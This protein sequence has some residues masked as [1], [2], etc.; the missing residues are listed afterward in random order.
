MGFR[1][2][3]LRLYAWFAVALLVFSAILMISPIAEADTWTE[4]TN[5][6]F[7][8]GMFAGTEIVGVGAIAAVQ[9][10][11]TH[12]DWV[13][14]TPERMPEP[15]DGYG[16]AYDKENQV[17]TL[18]GGYIPG[19]GNSNET[20]E[21]DFE[22]NNWTRIVTSGSPPARSLPGMAYDIM[23]EV[24]VLF[25]GY[26]DTGFLDDTWEYHS[27]N[28]TWIEI[29][30]TPHPSSMTSSPMVFDTTSQRIILVGEEVGSSDFQTWRY[31]AFQH[32][33]SELHPTV[34]PPSR[35]GHALA[36]DK[37]GGRVVLFGGAIGMNLQG[38]TWEYDAFNNMW[39]LT[40][41]TGPS[42]RVSAAMEYLPF[43]EGLILF[44]GLTSNG[45]EN[46]T[47]LYTS[48]GAPKWESLF[49]TV[50]PEGRRYIEMEYDY[51]SDMIL[52]FSGEKNSTWFNDTWL[53]GPT[54]A[55]EGKYGSS[56]YDS[57][58][59][60]TDWSAIW[61]NQTIAA[62]PKHTK[63]LVQLA[64]SNF[65]IGPFSFGG[66]DGSHETYYE[67]GEGE[68]IW[69]GLH[70]RFLKYGVTLRSYH[71][72]QTPSL[73]DITVAFNYVPAPPRILRTEPYDGEINVE[74]DAAVKIYFSERTDTSTVQVNIQPNITFWREWTEGDTIL[75]LHHN[76]LFQE[77]TTYTIE[78][79]AKD[80]DGNGLVPGP[81]PNP[82]TFN[83]E[84]LYPYIRYYTPDH[85][86]EEIALT[87]PIEIV[88][89]ES[90]NKSTFIWNITPDPGGWSQSWSE[91]DSKA[92]LSHSNL[93]DLCTWYQV[94]VR[95]IE[96]LSG[97]QLVPHHVANPWNFKSFCDAP[98]II[99]TVPGPFQP[100]V[101]INE[102][103]YIGFS[104]PMDQS[105]L[106][107]T[108]DP[109]PG[110]W[111]EAWS[112]PVEV[113]LHHANDFVECTS[114]TVEVT[115]AKDLSGKDLRPNEVPN[116]WTFTTVC[117]SPYIMHTVPEDG[118]ADVPV[119]GTIYIAFSE[120]IDIASFTWE[121]SPDI[122]AWAEEWMLS[123][124]QLTPLGVLDECTNH[125]LEVTYAQ[126]PSGN[127]LIPGPV[128]NPFTFKTVC[129][130]PIILWTEP[131]DQAQG[132]PLDAPILVKWNEPMN[133]SAFTLEIDPDIELVANWN[134]AEDLVTLTHGEDF[135]GSTTY[136]A[137]ADG[138]DKE[139]HQWRP[140]PTP[141]PWKFTTIPADNPY[142][143]S[144][145]PE[146]GEGNVPFYKD[147]TVVFSKPM[148][149]STVTWNISQGMTLTGSWSNGSTRLVLTH[150][151]PFIECANY[152]IEVDGYD[153]QGLRLAPPKAW[154]FSAVCYRPY[155]VST[156]P[157]DGVV[158]VP[159]NETIVVEFS[160]TI[161]ETT[162]EWDINP[163]PGGW[164][165]EWNWNSSIAYFYHS[166]NF[167]ECLEYDVEM[168]G[169][170]D[171]DDRLMKPGLVPNPWGFMSQCGSPY[172][173][174]TD[175]DHLQEE[176]PFDYPLTVVF[177]EPMETNTVSWSLDPNYW[178]PDTI[179]F[180]VQWFDNDTRVVFS[181]VMD[182]HVCQEYSFWIS[183]AAD[184]DY[185]QLVPGPVPN[186]FNFT[187]VCPN[188]Y[189][190]L[191][192]PSHGE[193]DVTL[194]VPI[195]IRFSETMN[196]NT[197]AWTITPDP[198]GWSQY[199][200][201]SDSRVL[202][203]HSNL[204]GHCTPYEV[205]VTYIEDVDGNSLI[206]GP[207]PL[208]ETHPNPWMFKTYC[209]APFIVSTSPSDMEQGVPTNTSVLITFSEAIDPSSFLFTVAP[210]FGGWATDW[211]TM[212]EVYLNRSFDLPECTSE[213]VHV[214]RAT[215]LEAKHL[216]PGPVPN[217]WTFKTVCPN[218]QILFTDPV[219]GE[220]GVPLDAPLVVV[221]D[222]PMDQT[223]LD[224]TINPEPG[225]WTVVWEG[226]YTML[227]LSHSNLFAIDTVYEA[228][229]VGILD[230]QGNPLVPGPV[231]N[232]WQFTTGETVSAPADLQVWR[233]FPDDVTVV[234]DPVGGATSY[235]VYSTTDRFEPW[236]WAS[237]MDITAPATWATFAGHLSDGLDH[238][239][240]VRAYNDVLGKESANSTM[241]AKVD[242]TFV[243]NP[244][245]AS[246]YWMSLPY[247]SMYSKA[248]DIADEL[249][250]TR[251]NII[252]KWDR[253]KQEY[254]SY[255]Y[256][257][258]KWRGRDFTLNPGD[259]FYVSAVSDFAWYINGTDFGTS[260]DFGFM[261]TPTKRN[262][263]WISLPLTSIYARAS[264][265]V[266][267]IEGSLGPGNNT[268][269]IEV[270]K[271]DPLNEREIVFAYDGLGWSG[272]DFD[273]IAGEGICLQVVSSFSWSPR[274]L[275]PSVD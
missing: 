181:H 173:V 263:H 167:T 109:D 131:A 68:T 253:G 94:E 31:D 74:V 187:T 239:Y 21:Y 201:M 62:R 42:P 177:S 158:Q 148:N 92:V 151:E 112:N 70:G 58:Y 251:V 73:E 274:L 17:M 110:G 15:R 122:G 99:S 29:I 121:I 3:R 170:K 80:M 203:S 188:P 83:V 37:K 207:Y 106:V 140:S 72:L 40:M 25:G 103:I 86:Q 85:Q 225:D 56:L 8:D 10:N 95:Y 51:R 174:S 35:S 67:L 120:G 219:D 228:E 241:G 217:P 186:P 242:A 233:T 244:M 133:V 266:I 24:T 271:W 2:L 150:A 108:I 190:I 50:A 79:S 18:F 36:Y 168:I 154:F 160:E 22:G 267:D 111:S 134:P 6:D 164:V 166:V 209:D 19:E 272:D 157:E 191:E 138:Y 117:D 123:V 39:V 196:K 119:N 105:S 220:G 169:F 247:R 33:W 262:A 57:G 216:V 149:E 178:P 180:T 226:N 264:D 261:P 96:D 14:M 4:T 12:D 269:I 26:G 214:T 163:D 229:V 75:T 136:T 1:R 45:F 64:A 20:W 30:T 192:A 100:F 38:D 198:G 153:W 235:H 89:S 97:N 124:L 179:V 128:P 206:P 208:N 11:R 237:M 256:A 172:I 55:P 236:P 249:T 114:Y 142:I 194:T 258:G 135:I 118:A 202:L 32:T 59:A 84:D 193:V 156:S 141:N 76:E 27:S 91:N 268:K 81:V 240:I 77:S 195:E 245:K 250:E 88:F 139:G 47:W 147:I 61:W 211:M 260:L 246:L 199:W 162:L 41:Q 104:E 69:E 107:W 144:K 132:V 60:E 52:L 197:F 93:Y 200:N 44:G 221:F 184:K 259:G 176:V 252:A 28:H 145:D 189:I 212:S 102:S 46:E 182:F 146:I 159:L 54:Y 126:D 78:I 265:V 257:R 243:H 185:N 48:F 137:Y 7:A 275:T 218:P 224:W 155:I 231:P 213:T 9:I 143:V 204:F 183:S 101:E 254:E 90:M 273:I 248:S 5:A 113:G 161:N 130:H 87:T 49:T 98:Y 255:Y 171:M 165:I 125:T 65:S 71:G 66:P 227:V 82:W 232:P 43:W 127:A 230:M 63:L 34:E 13:N 210:T 215:D 16:L 223:T 129:I 175:P 116:P 115:Q 53:F 23:D 234:W 152:D 270:R 238:Y 205:E 222:R